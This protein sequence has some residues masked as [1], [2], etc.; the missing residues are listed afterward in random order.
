MALNAAITWLF[1]A[2]LHYPAWVP[3][4]P[5]ILLASLVTFVLNRMW[6]FG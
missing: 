1:T 4:V 3:L 2:M 6:V 5:A